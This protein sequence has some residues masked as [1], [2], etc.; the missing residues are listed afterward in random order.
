MTSKPS[1]SLLRICDPVQT[2]KALRQLYSHNLVTE[3]R[4]LSGTERGS[5]KYVRNFY[6]Y[7]DSGDAVV[8]ALEGIGS[9]KGVYFS[10]NPVNPKLMS[11][12]NNRLKQGEKG[13]ATDD[14]LIVPPGPPRSAAR[15][16][17]KRKP[18]TGERPCR[19]GSQSGAGRSLSRPTAATVPTSST[20]STS[21]TGK[22]SA[23]SSSVA[24]RR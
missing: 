23:A 18:S 10:I 13:S 2:K 12:A 15:T 7:F 20:A 17:R 24:S 11:R 22:R 4:V 5:P 6:G 14:D 1:P 9:A 21:R 3:I 19:N 16:W 8:K